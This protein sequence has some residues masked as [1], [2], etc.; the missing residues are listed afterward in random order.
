MANQGQ[1]STKQLRFRSQGFK[2][3]GP[4]SKKKLLLNYD[5]SFLKSKRIFVLYYLSGNKNLE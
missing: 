1:G 2:D 5:C 3:I 4:F